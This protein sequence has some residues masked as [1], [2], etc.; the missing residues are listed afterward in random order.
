MVTVIMTCLVI[1]GLESFDA[2]SLV[3]YN[4]WGEV[5]FQQDNYHNTF[6]GYYKN[7]VSACRQLLLC[8]Q[9]VAR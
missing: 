2:N 9:I 5:V 7:Q 6:N 3:I 4:R 8:P 1:K